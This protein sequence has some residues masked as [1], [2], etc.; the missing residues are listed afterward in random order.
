MPV[1]T[2]NVS[3]EYAMIELA[4]RAGAIDRDRTIAESLVGIRR[5]G[6]DVILTYWAR[7][8]ADWIRAGKDFA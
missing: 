4:A 8:V 5:A 2:Y 3:G 1:A 6:A 7:E